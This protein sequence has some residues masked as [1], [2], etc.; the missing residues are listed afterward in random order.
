MPNVKSTYQSNQPNMPKSFPGQHQNEQPGSQQQMNPKPVTDDPNYKGS[1]KL[2]DL[3]A[4]ITGGDSG[5]GQAAAL[6]FAKE[7][8]NIVIAYYS[9]NEDAN[10]TVN[11]VQS[12]GRKC[13]AVK[14]DLKKEES[15]KQVI[16]T[17]MNE[18]GKI[19]VLVNNIAVQY[20]QNSIL[21]I[22]SEI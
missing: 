12:V 8:A 20:P 22:T 10:D 17:A 2:K 16:D 9:E 5:I 19:D 21:D 1:N 4:V 18:L 6:A 7:G 3:V 13:I 15:A 14:C 11:M